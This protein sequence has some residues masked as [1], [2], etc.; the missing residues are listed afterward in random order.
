VYDF[1]L[2]PGISHPTGNKSD[3]KRE[4]L[5]P[6]INAS[7]MAQ[8]IEKTQTDAYIDFVAKYPD[9]KIGQR[10]I[11]SLL[12][13]RK[14]RFQAEDSLFNILVLT[15]FPPE[16]RLAGIPNCLQ[17]CILHLDF[18]RFSHVFFLVTQM[19]FGTEWKNQEHLRN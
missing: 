7:H 13:L 14:V 16:I 1:W 9:I 10:K 6:N 15:R 4:R 11:V 2:S 3:I 17:S 12:V 18:S 19:F 8:V 5:G